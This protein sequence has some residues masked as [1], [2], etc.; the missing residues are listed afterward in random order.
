ML[1]LAIPEATKRWHQGFY[2]QHVCP[3]IWNNLGI[4]FSSLPHQFLIY[5]HISSESTSFLAC[6]Y[7]LIFQFL[8]SAAINSTVPVKY[9]SAM[10][11]YLL[12]KAALRYYQS[13]I[14]F[15]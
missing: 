2:V 1:T 13:E 11:L 6:L 3:A 14:R 15:L 4:W 7:L 8:S 10:Q 9:N 12:C 5:F